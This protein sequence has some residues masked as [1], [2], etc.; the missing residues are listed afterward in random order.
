M[1]V[2]VEVNTFRIWK[3]L[4]LIGR[5][6]H[7]LLLPM[8]IDLH[9][10]AEERPMATPVWGIPSH[11]LYDLSNWPAYGGQFGQNSKPNYSLWLSR[12][13]SSS[14][15]HIKMYL[16][17]LSTLLWIPDSNIARVN[18]YHHQFLNWTIGTWTATKWM[19]ICD[20]YCHLRK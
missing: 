11:S 6:C 14:L 7:P 1:L 18:D 10:K 16:H 20:G 12:I 4:P 2:D 8:Y 13:L 15:I 17:I 5:G 3:R 19:H 9:H